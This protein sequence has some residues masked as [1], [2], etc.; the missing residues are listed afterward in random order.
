MSDKHNEL[1]TQ[2]DLDNVNASG[3]SGLSLVEILKNNLNGSDN[4]LPRPSVRHEQSNPPT[5]LEMPSLGAL[6]KQ[7]Q[8]IIKN[9]SP[10]ENNK[11]PSLKSLLDGDK[12]KDI[13]REGDSLWDERK[14]RLRDLLGESPKP[15]DDEKIRDYA[16][17]IASIIGK[18]VDFSYGGKNEKIQ[19]LFGEAAKA[20]D[21]S[22]NKLLKQVN[23]ELEERGIQVKG[24]FKIV[25]KVDVVDYG[26]VMLT[27][28]PPIYPNATVRRTKTAEIDLS[29]N[30]L[31]GDEDSLKFSKSISDVTKKERYREVREVKEWIIH[32]KFGKGIIESLE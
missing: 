8:N 25:D 27:V 11:L 5:E 26:G 13:Y 2:Q 29:L 21:E 22:F 18:N 20:G 1:E 14:D 17:S 32:P 19:T 3:A 7:I 12:W 15:L 31:K 23:K 6:T 28:D 30:S 9:T 24:G 16:K 4:V 10:G